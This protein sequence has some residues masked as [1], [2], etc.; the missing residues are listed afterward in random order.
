MAP[1]AAAAVKPRPR[2]AALPAVVKRVALVANEKGGVGKSV[3]TRT[4]V[5]H[6]RTSGKRV[7]AYGSVGATARVLG[8]RD[9][10][11]AV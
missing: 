11:G 3:F 1:A 9:A 8:C 7:A 2:A 6:L 10:S 4:L 5:D